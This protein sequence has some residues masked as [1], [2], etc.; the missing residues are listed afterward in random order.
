M[1]SSDL[2]MA[3]EGTSAQDGGDG[4]GIMSFTLNG[5]GGP[6]VGNSGGFYPSSAYGRVSTT[7]HGLLG[8]VSDIA[9]LGQSPQDGFSEYQG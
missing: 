4:L 6:S 2:T 7:S 1:C 9:D 5:N 8:S 3:A